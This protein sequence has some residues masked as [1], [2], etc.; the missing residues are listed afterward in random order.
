AVALL[1][2]Q[3]CYNLFISP[4]RRHPGPTL[5]AL[6]SIPFSRLMVSGRCHVEALELHM[7][8]GPVVRVGPKELIYCHP[9][10]WRAIA[11]R[12]KAGAKEH[13]KDPVFFKRSLKSIIAA[14]RDDHSRIRRAL[15][16]GFSAK[17]MIDQQPIIMTYV[18]LLLKRLHE[19]CDGGRQAMDMVAWYNWTTFDIVGDLT[20]GEPFDCLQNSAYHPWIANIFGSMKN[21]A[22][23]SQLA[24]IPILEG[25]L[26]RFLPKSIRHKMEAHHALTLAK[27]NKRLAMEPGRLD[28]TDHMMTQ[29]GSVSVTFEEM[30]QTFSTLV[31][32]GSETTATA[33]SAATYYL[34]THPEVLAK[35]NT[36]VRSQ[37]TSEREI[38]LTT[39]QNLPY[40]L[41]VLK[42]AMR[43]YPPLP[44]GGP[45]MIAE[46]GDVI[47][48]RFVP[49]GTVVHAWN[50]PICHHPDYFAMPE[51]FIPER[52]LD[53]NR[54]A[55][56]KREAFLPFSFGPRDCL[57]QNL[58]YSEMKLILARLVWNFDIKGVPG[59]QN[60]AKESEIFLFWEKGPLNMYLTPRSRE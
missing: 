39:V 51:S 25:L 44:T 22:F 29:K 56:D 26:M 3:A 27:V 43:V 41:A 14:P 33:L 55:N 58:A 37:F 2:A 59:S 34:S 30:L 18:D 36:E 42:E 21:L 1:A 46:E 20:F 15:W 35:L 4:L 54:F 6:S 40:M 28:F 12:P 5:W 49:G 50:W 24:K 7:K 53:D 32:A 10:A 9:D 11:G 13:G 31:I 19:Q 38:D 60:W 48:D 8:Y 47:L 45:R 52:W 16:P 57:G 23:S 17:A